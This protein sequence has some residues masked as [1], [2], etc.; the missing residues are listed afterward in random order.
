MTLRGES[1]LAYDSGSDDRERFLIFSTEQNLDLLEHTPQWHA[2]GTF[3]CCPALFYQLYKLHGVLNGHTIPFVYMLP[4]R[5]TRVIRKFPSKVNVFVTFVN[6]SLSN[7][8]PTKSV[9]LLFLQVASS[10]SP[11]PTGAKYKTLD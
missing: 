11:K 2:D 9:F 10:S 3:K 5:I 6:K 4:K 8:F 1:F 7:S